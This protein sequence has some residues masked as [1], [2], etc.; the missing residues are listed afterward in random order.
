MQLFCR[1]FFPENN[2][3]KHNNDKHILFDNAVNHLRGKHYLREKKIV[4]R[5]IKL[6]DKRN[7]N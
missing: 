2:C 5:I 1:F 3:D 7:K 6:V 4:V